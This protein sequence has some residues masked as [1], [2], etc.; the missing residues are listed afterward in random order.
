MAKWITLSDTA[1]K[2]GIRKGT[3]C[4]WRNRK[5]FPFKTKGKG[6]NLLIDASSVDAW[7][8]DHK[9]DVRKGR[10]KPRKPLKKTRKKT[11]KKVTRKVG[12]KVRK[13]PG[14]KP[15]RKK[16]GPKPGRRPGARRGRKPG[17]KPGRRPGPKAAKSSSAI[18]VE[19]QLDLGLI[20]EFIAQIKAGYDVQISPSRKGYLLTTVR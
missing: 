15:G 1:E 7:M 19:G 2:V 14:P 12:K 6:R 13:K 11:A 17:P 9:D 5:K 8:V 4:M 16:P 3:L 10:N 18:M 20:Q